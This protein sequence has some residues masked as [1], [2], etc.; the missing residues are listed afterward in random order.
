M[1]SSQVTCVQNA[2]CVLHWLSSSR[3]TSCTTWCVHP[4]SER[5]SYVPWVTRDVSIQLGVQ[6]SGMQGRVW[7]KR[8]SPHVTP[9]HAP[10]PSIVNHVHSSQYSSQEELYGSQ[11]WL[12]S[13]P[14]ALKVS[15]V[16]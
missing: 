6:V 3:V 1:L 13:W 8:P 2:E 14:Y 16:S 7:W 15:K 4:F 11:T 9:T 5:P 12:Q 10:Q